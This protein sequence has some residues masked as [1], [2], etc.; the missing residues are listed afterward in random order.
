MAQ[1]FVP[2]D[3]DQAL[4]LPPNIVDWLPENHLVWFVLDAVDEFDLSA[5][6]AHYRTGAQGR[7]AY[8]PKMMVALLLYAYATGVRSSRDIERRLH[9]DVA[10]RAIAVNRA[11]DHAT[12]C[13]FRRA[14]EDALSELFVQVVGLCVR[15]GMVQTTIVA[16]DGTKISANAAQARNYSDEKLKELA[17]KVLEEAEAADAKE[18]ELYGDR[19]GDEI[20]DELVDRLKRLE[21]L[22]EELAKR[23]A[24]ERK[25]REK[26]INA[27]D[28]ESRVMKTP[29]GYTQGYNAQLAASEDH[30]IVAADLTNEAGDVAQL[31]PMLEQLQSNLEAVDAAPAKTIVADAGYLSASNVG[32]DTDAELLISPTTRGDLDAA[33]KDRRDPDEVGRRDHRH[34]YP[35]P[36]YERRCEVIEAYVAKQITAK[37]AATA[38]FAKIATIYFWAWQLRHSG[39]VAPMRNHRPPPVPTA[40]D[41]MLERLADPEARDRYKK[42]SQTVEPVIGHI[43]ELRGLRRFLHRGLAACRCE[44]RMMATAQNLRRKWAVAT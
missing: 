20:P 34:L 41:I 44:L 24:P 16:I 21:W 8:D 31:E 37:E 12:I 11:I 9:D 17:A 22:R 32:L 1:A 29:D 10:F 39:R 13:R 30:F 15:A 42:R 38:L 7:A 5:L 43:K 28:P 3:R 36:T 33:I 6:Y 25:N 23:P 35:S 27:T 2:V 4:L 14:H 19:R 26:K 18:D 40:K